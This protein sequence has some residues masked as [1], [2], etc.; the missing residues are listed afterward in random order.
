VAPTLVISGA[1]DAG[2]PP[3]RGR[4]IAAAIPGARF[5]AL[6]AAHIANIEQPDAFGAAVEDFLG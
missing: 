2:T 3:E 5:L 6:D 4:E 1:H